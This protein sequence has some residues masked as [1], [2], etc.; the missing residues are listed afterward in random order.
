MNG[1]KNT[2][3]LSF[4]GAALGFGLGLILALF[5]MSKRA[6]VRAPARI[7][8]NFFRGTPLIW[9]LS[10]AGLGVVTALRLGF[11]SGTTAR[12]RWPSSSSG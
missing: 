5:T 6:V 7:Y 1:A 9:Q 12:T 2:L 3:I 4:A 8:I 10:F 11:F